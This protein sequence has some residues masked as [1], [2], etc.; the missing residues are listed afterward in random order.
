MMFPRFGASTGALR[1]P[2]W[3]PIADVHRGL[4]MPARRRTRA[5]DRAT[6]IRYERGINEVRIAV[7]AEARRRAALDDPPPF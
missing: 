7:E 3:T 5:A 2:A 4:M 1:L 6:R